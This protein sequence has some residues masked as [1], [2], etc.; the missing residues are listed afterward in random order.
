MSKEL[1]RLLVLQHGISCDE[2]SPGEIRRRNLP[3][4]VQHELL[5]MLKHQELPEEKKKKK[6][7]NKNKNKNKR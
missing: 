1:C 3:P 7:K 2:S 6:N 4:V 5:A